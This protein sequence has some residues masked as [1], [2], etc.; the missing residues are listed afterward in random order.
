MVLVPLLVAKVSG[1]YLQLRGWH[2]LNSVP[3]ECAQDTRRQTQRGKEIDKVAESST[4][5]YARS[6]VR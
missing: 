4:R 3:R 6:E 5:V 1:Q 2:A